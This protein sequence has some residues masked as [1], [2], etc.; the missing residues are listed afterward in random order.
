MPTK[1]DSIGLE[2]KKIPAFKVESTSGEVVKAADF[3][4]SS[5]ILYFYPKDST[6]GCTKEGEDFRD[7]FAKFKK[8]GVSIFGISRDS[9]SSHEKFK[10]KYNFPFELLSD[11]E[12]SMCKAF[13]VLQ[14]KSMY[15]RKF[16]GVERS[17]FFIENGKVLKEW[18][19]VKVPGH[20]NAVLDYIK[21]FK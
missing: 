16:L 11:S 4:N 19:K 9:L 3:K 6:S 13:D 10:N 14:M 12:E 18:R 7:S 8:M 15:G 5:A 20:V 21:S 2:G 1:K 17:T